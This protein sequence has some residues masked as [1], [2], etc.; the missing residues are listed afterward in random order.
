MFHV[1][2]HWLLQDVL[3][4]FDFL[5]AHL[6]FCSTFSVGHREPGLVC[7]VVLVFPRAGGTF[8]LGGFGRVGD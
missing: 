1:Q 2:S 7:A 6:P 8:T 4:E 5:L 3:I